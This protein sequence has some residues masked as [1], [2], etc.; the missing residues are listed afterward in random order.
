MSDLVT[1]QPMDTEPND[2]EF[3]LYGLYVH[4]NVSDQWWFEVH[5]VAMDDG[6]QLV[7]PSGDNFDD[8]AFDDFICWAPAPANVPPRA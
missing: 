5:Y 4:S 1:W 3:R 7:L 8:W 6:G 2:G